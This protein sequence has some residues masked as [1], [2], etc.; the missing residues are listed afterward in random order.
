MEVRCEI[1]KSVLQQLRS[2]HCNGACVFVSCGAVAA[3]LLA[4]FYRILRE[5]LKCTAASFEKLQLLEVDA[6]LEEL[7]EDGPIRCVW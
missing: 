1:R 6:V 2:L 3:L 4:Q 5:V 7:I